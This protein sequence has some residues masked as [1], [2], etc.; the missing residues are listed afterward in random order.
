MKMFLKLGYCT[1][2]LSPSKDATMSTFWGFSSLFVDV[3]M[4][5]FP[6]KVIIAP[7]VKI[8]PVQ[9][10]NVQENALVVDHYIKK[11]IYIEDIT[12]SRGDTKFL[13]EC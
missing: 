3:L 6:S 2:S 1:L 11:S 13:F 7:H 8:H 9:E 4:S 12:W 10:R 5:F